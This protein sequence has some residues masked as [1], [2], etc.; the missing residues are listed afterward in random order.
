[1][2][3]M[4]FYKEVIQITHTSATSNDVV[5]VKCQLCANADIVSEAKWTKDRYLLGN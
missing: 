2:L 4:E 3:V 5:M 1:M